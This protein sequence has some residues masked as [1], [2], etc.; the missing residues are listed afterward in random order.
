MKLD[1][2]TCGGRT[3]SVTEAIQSVDPDA[4]IEANL[5]A[6]AVKLET[7][8]TPAALQQLLEEAR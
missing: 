6:R 8:A 2:M 5:A 7:T 3:K 1:G 4:R